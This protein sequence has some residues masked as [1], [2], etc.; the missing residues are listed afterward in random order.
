MEKTLQ[1]P[2]ANTIFIGILRDI[3]PVSAHSF[4]R[5]HCDI[6]SG[7]SITAIS[8]CCVNNH[9]LSRL[10]FKPDIVACWTLFCI[11]FVKD[12][13]NLISTL[14]IYHLFLLQFFF[15]KHMS[16]SESLQYPGTIEICS[17]S[18]IKPV[19]SIQSVFCSFHWI[20]GSISNL[21]F[22]NVRL[23][24]CELKAVIQSPVAAE[25]VIVLSSASGKHCPKKSYFSLHFTCVVKS[26]QDP[27]YF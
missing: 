27:F 12:C 14:H 10:C 18:F 6:L 19:F 9:F 26:D 24:R 20:R 15:K 21:C 23:L 8:V 13:L 25:C 3:W 4:S 16:P 1:N 11:L 2:A 22:W 17:E 5:V 7:T